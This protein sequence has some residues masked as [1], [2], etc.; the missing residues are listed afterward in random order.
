V[1][2]LVQVLLTKY[3]QYTFTLVLIKKFDLKAAKWHYYKK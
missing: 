2:F 3:I 1:L